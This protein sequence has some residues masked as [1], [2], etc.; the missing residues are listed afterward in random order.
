MLVLMV[1]SET[2]VIEQIS[3]LVLKA[4]NRER[5]LLASFDP[6]SCLRG[7]DRETSFISVDS[8]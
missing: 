7:R 8:S 2:E 3:D 6:L 5:Y 4:T 1:K